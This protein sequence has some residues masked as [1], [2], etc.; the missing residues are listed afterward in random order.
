MVPSSWMKFRFA[1]AARTSA[2]FS[3]FTSRS[4]AM[5]LWRNSALSSKSNLASSTTTS[6]VLVTAS[7]LTSARVASFSRNTFASAVMIFSAFAACSPVKPSSYASRRAWNGKQP[8]SGDDRHLDDLL[9]V[10]GRDLLDVHPALGAGHEHRHADRAV[11]HHREVELLR[12]LGVG[13]HDERVDRRP[14]RAGLLRLERVLEHRLGD[15]LRLLLARAELDPAE[16]VRVAHEL[17][18]AAAAG[19]DLGL[20]HDPAAVAASWSN[21]AAAS[22]GVLHDDVPGH[23]RAGGGEQLLGLVLVNLHA[24]LPVG[25]S[26][27]AC[28]RRRRLTP[29]R[30]A[31]MMGVMLLAARTACRTGSPAIGQPHGP[32]RPAAGDPVRVPRHRV[33]GTRTPQHP[34]RVPR[35]K[36]SEPGRDNLIATYEPPGPAPFT[37]LFEAHQDTVPVDAM[38]IEPFGATIEGGRLYGRGSCDVKA[39]V[40]VMLGALRR[41]VKEKPAGS[42]K[43]TSRLPWTRRTAGSGIQ[44]LM[45]SGLRADCAIV[46][47]PTLLNIVNAHKG[48]ARWPLETTGKACHS[49][50]PELGVNA[51]YRMARLAAGN[52]GVLRRSCEA[53]PAR[54]PS[55]ARG[56]S[57]SA[58]SPAACRRTPSPTQCFARLDRRLLPGETYESATADLDAFLRAMPDV[59]FPFTLTSSSPGCLPL[60]PESSRRTRS[61][62]SGRRSIPSLGSTRSTRSRSGRTPQRWPRRGCRPWCSVPAISPKPHTKDEWID[63]AQL[64]PAAE[65]LFRFACGQ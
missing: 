54:P 5:S 3:S 33:P 21:A 57:R 28:Y 1:F 53:L 2:G 22:S 55:W 45:R 29:E 58:A 11:E 36:T 6:P 62:V 30:G 47:E 31:A 61:A 41:L 32:H 27:A 20:H 46:A 15:G 44:E 23:V 37:V 17:A 34:L 16:L 60:G 19:V 52:R 40:A 38:T 10:L 9:R 64:E 14:V 35:V 48:V 63:L 25:N 59:D 8:V 39:G 13:L 50:R 4:A 24:G 49:S 18:R 42:A 26:V 12:G 56:R 43:V 65:I 7:G 51:V